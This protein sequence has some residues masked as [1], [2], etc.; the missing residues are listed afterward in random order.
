MTNDTHYLINKDGLWWWGNKCCG[1]GKVLC[2]V[3][4]MEGDLLDKVLV[5]ANM[6]AMT[7]AFFC[8]VAQKLEKINGGVKCEK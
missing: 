7:H 8:R 5:A 2:V 4:D 1:C 6:D 3:T